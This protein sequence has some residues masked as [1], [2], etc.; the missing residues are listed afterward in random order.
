MA[1]RRGTVELDGAVFTPRGRQTFR[2]NVRAMLAD[3]AFSGE[4]EARALVA[5]HRRTGA[6]EESIHGRVQSLNGRRWALT[7]VV[8]SQLNRTRGRAS[9][10][11]Y[12]ETGVR[13]REKRT[14]VGKD[15]RE[16]TRNVGIRQG[17]FRG[18]QMFRQTARG[19]RAGVPDLTK[20]LE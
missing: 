15:G 20:G 9:Y 10:A 6:L 11:G 2:Q 16:R 17:R 8:S 14:T 1:V 7:A 4:T 3:I 12:I 5:S 13:R 18:V 19:L